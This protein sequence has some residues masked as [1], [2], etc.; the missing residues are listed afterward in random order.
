V[1][2]SATKRINDSSSDYSPVHSERTFA[3]FFA[4][5]GLMRMGLERRG[6]SI[7]FANDIDPQKYEMY[8]IHFLDADKHFLLEDIHKI[9]G[10]DIPT[11]I[12]ATASFPCNDL[13]LAGTRQGLGGK[14]SSSFWG[15][16]RILEEMGKRRPPLILLE[17]VF[18]FLSSHAGKDFEKALLA[19]NRLGYCVDAFALDAASFVPQ[20][21]LRLF[22]VGTSFDQCEMH[23]PQKSLLFYQSAVRPKALAGFILMHPKIRWRIRDLPS[24]PQN[25]S[26]LDTVLED[27]PETASEWWSSERADYLLSQMSA[28]HREIAERMISGPEWNYGAVFRRVRNGKSMAELRVDGLA[29]CLRTPRGGSGR[30]ILFKAGG[31]RFFARL[32]TSREA[33][34]LMGAGDYNIGVQLN[35]ALF[36]FGDAVCVPAIEWIAENYLNPIA[37]QLFSEQPSWHAL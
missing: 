7:R 21:R 17:N 9:P 31:G 20:S 37:E 33:A 24:P 28:R 4:G 10:K 1:E 27:L 32:M 36:G 2:K 34:R 11:V 5:I 30:Q 16:I 13:S 12:L 35:R 25:T 23:E 26:R 8:K 19:L 6:W 14:H 18:G 22:V 15:F 3:E 29:G